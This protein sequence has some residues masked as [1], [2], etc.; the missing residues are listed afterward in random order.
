[1]VY[2]CYMVNDRVMLVVIYVLSIEWFLFLFRQVF[3]RI[4]IQMNVFKYNI[5]RR[6]KK[7]KK[8]SF[9][10]SFFLSS[11]RYDLSVARIYRVVVIVNRFCRQVV[12]S[13][14]SLMTPIAAREN[15]PAKVPQTY[16]FIWP[17]SVMGSWLLQLRQ[18]QSPQTNVTHQFMFNPNKAFA[19]FARTACMFK[20]RP[21]HRM[22]HSWVRQIIDGVAVAV[23]FSASQLSVLNPN[24]QQ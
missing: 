8:F 14:F 23:M 20:R 22:P 6:W 1:M 4:R 11:L 3:C 9:F 18:A 2:I 10:L 15:A 5:T 24:E 17:A 7:K 19:P 12:Y 21:R 13:A 16:V